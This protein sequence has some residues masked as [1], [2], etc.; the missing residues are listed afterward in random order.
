MGIYGLTGDVWL[1]LRKCLKN[2]FSLPIKK[3]RLHLV[4]C[5]TDA[6]NLL[7]PFGK[8]AFPNYR[9]CA[10]YLFRHGATKKPWA[11]GLAGKHII[12]HRKPDPTFLGVG[13]ILDEEG[14]RSHI[15]ATL[16]AAKGCS[17]EFTQRDVYQVSKSPEKVRRYVE[18]LREACENR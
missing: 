13:D 15:N 14:L 18:I 3:W 2:S 9:I 5:P 8:A 1:F 4:Y 10:G 6:V 16:D 12:Y 17:L 7:T 11:N